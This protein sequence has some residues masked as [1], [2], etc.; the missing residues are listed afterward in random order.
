MT[1]FFAVWIV[2]VL[3]FV[4]FKGLLPSPWQ[5]PVGFLAF[6]IVLLTFRSVPRAPDA[7]WDRPSK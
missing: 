6:G 1:C 5:Y 7:A 4:L 3:A 2:L